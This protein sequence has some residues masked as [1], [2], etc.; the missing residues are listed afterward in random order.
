MLTANDCNKECT[1]TTE[2]QR[3]GAALRVG[4]IGAGRMGAAM[5][6][7][8]V[9]AGEDLTVWNRTAAKAEPLADRGRRRS[10]TSIAELAD[11]DVVFTMVSTRPT[12]S[13]CCSARAAC[14]STGRRGPRSSSTARRSPPRRRR[15]SA[16]ACAERGV[17][18]LAAPV[19]GNA[20]VVKAGKLT[21][22]VSG[23]RG[24]LRRGR[25]RC[26]TARPRP[27][28]TSARAIWRGW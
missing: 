14:S 5:A 12:S 18:F 15:R 19:S 7:R 4:W 6:I 25:A 21:L 28:P 27:S 22:A 24:H 16:T 8:V 9:N 23:P 11:R 20:K 1:M 3:N 26:S 17:D 13:R 10:P 2:T